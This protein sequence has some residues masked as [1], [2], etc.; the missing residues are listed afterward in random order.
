[1]RAA[2]AEEHEIGRLESREADSPGAGDLAAQ[3]VA[4]PAAQ[5]GRQAAAVRV[6]AELVDA[7]GKAR[8]VEAARLQDAERRLRQ[9]ARSAPDVR[10]ADQGDRSLGD[11]A[12]PA[13]EP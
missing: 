1:M 4:R 8:A 12:R 7:P 3:G 5:R 13:G 6:A 11:R 9:L 10:V 2:A